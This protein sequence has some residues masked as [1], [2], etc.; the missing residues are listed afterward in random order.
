MYLADGMV[1]RTPSAPAFN[2]HLK[3]LNRL[4]VGKTSRLGVVLREWDG[5]D[6]PNN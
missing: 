6:S 3:K 1:S 5:F 2:A 4:L